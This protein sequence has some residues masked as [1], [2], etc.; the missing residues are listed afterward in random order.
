[1]SLAGG[2]SDAE[3][4]VGK[5]EEVVHVPLSGGGVARAVGQRLP[6][7]APAV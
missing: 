6:V 5:V 7:A 3:L 1:M 2:T 4:H